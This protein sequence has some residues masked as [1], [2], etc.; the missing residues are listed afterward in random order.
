MDRRSFLKLG[1]AGAAVGAFGVRSLGSVL[2]GAFAADGPYGP[3]LPADANGLQ[4]PAGYSSRVVAT[5]G[6]VVPGTSYTW[7]GH[8]DGGACFPAPGD[9]WVYVSNSERGSGAGGA[10]STCNVGR[11]STL[12]SR[13][14]R[15]CEGALTARARANTAL[16]ARRGAQPPP[17][18]DARGT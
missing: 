8:P 16:T 3:L 17:S 1:V 6:A 10:V 5:S 7:H 13:T 4:L 18:C 15:T 9:G 11:S 14:V 2:P 12:T